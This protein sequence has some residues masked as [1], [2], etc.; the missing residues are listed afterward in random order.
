METKTIFHHFDMRNY[1]LHFL[2]GL[3]LS[4]TI[5]SINIL[6]LSYNQ[7]TYKAIDV[8]YLS[9]ELDKEFGIKATV[10]SFRKYKELLL[11]DDNLSENNVAFKLHKFS[12]SKDTIN[13]YYIK[14][15]E[16]TPY[17]VLVKSIDLCAKNKLDYLLDHNKIWILSVPI[18]HFSGFKPFCSTNLQH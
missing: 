9:E 18:K 17:W 10:A 15:T 3:I 12:K 4:T 1:T 14:F 16:K 11:P 8:A 5:F 7:S 2:L 6:L 13:G